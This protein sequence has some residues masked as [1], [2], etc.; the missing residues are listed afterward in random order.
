PGPPAKLTRRRRGTHPTHLGGAPMRLLAH[1]TAGLC[2]LSLF[3]LAAGSQ[4]SA[5]EKKGKPMTVKVGDK[6]PTF[7]GMDE[8]G[9]TWRSSDHVGKKIVVL[10]FYPADFTGGCTAQACGFR[11]DIEKLGTKDVEVVGVSGDSV[12]THQMF[13]THH[14]LP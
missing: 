6:A 5:G 8:T 2:V 7:E 4:L 14:K 13:K 11:D 3:A 12:K 9:K 10:Y 1:L